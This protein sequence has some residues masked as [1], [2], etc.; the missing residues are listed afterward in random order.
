MHPLCFQSFGTNRQRAK[1]KRRCGISDDA[2]CNICVFLY[3]N[4]LLASGMYV[5]VFFQLFSLFTQLGSA[6]VV[7]WWHWSRPDEKSVENETKT[8]TTNA[9][10]ESK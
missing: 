10:A 8:I 7:F 2:S 4:A 9:A 3:H 5:L 1:L 6:T